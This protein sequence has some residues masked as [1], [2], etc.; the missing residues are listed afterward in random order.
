MPQPP[1][2]PSSILLIMTDQQAL[3]TLSCYGA[4]VAR[5]PHIDALAA[6]GIRF[7]HACTPSALCT[8]ARASLLTGLY[9]HAHGVLFNTGVYS[10][11]DETACG[12]GLTLFPEKLA[13]AGYCLGH[14]GKW[15]AGLTPTATEAGFTGFSLRDYGGIRRDPTFMR[16]LKERG[17]PE[18]KPHFEFAAEGGDPAQSGGNTSGWAEGDIRSSPC[19]FITDQVLAQL[20]EFAATDQPFF[21]GCHYWEPH[22]PYLPTEDFKD[23]YDPADIPEWPSFRDDLTGRP[24]W[25]RRFRA[26]IFPAAAQASWADWAQVIARYYAQCAMV[27]QEVGRLLTGL[28]ERGLYENTLIIFASDHGESIGI[29]GGLFDKGGHAH[30]ELYR[31]PLIVKPPRASAAQRGRVC[32]EWVS[33]I[34]L[35]PTFCATAGTSMGNEIH[36]RDLSPLLQGDT[37][38]DWRDDL[39][40][41]DHGHRVM[42]VERILWHENWKYVFNP[43]DTDELY[44]L[45]ADPA[46]L[47]NRIDDPTMRSVAVDLRRRLLA[48]LQAVNDPLGP[49]TYKLLEDAISE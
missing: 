30:E 21:L 39:L 23:R 46:E 15:H 10:R 27:D 16:Y 47:S 3:H 22:A 7:D 43:S 24:H 33:L 38:A 42:F 25:H 29:H 40:A 37:P 19:H 26:S 35:A 14:Q 13:A 12:E 32:S 44:D 8:P 20:D 45:T 1:A 36:G 11:F 34:D 2:E 49:Q 5:S 17:L 41:E 4:P 18:P 6:D 48:R 28:K 31:I 9:P